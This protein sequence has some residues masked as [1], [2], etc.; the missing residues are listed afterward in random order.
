MTSHELAK[1]LL[2]LPDLPVVVLD[3]ADPSDW[4]EVTTITKATPISFYVDSN[5]MLV[6]DKL[7]IMIT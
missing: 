7:A 3:G 2:E 5:G 6:E 1:K 4:E